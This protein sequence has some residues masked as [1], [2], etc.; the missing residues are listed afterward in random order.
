M[1]SFNINKLNTFKTLKP[2]AVNKVITYG[3]SD[4]ITRRD[5]PPAFK[6]ISGLTF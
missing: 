5:K 3:I 6:N 2:P 4:E 1:A